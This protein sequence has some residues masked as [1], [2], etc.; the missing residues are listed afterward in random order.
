M[1]DEESADHENVKRENC[2][3]QTSKTKN[4]EGH[5]FSTAWGRVLPKFDSNYIPNLGEFIWR[6]C[7]GQLK[8]IDRPSESRFLLVPKLRLGMPGFTCRDASE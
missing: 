3:K 8:P 4:N 6:K 5:D 2:K 7:H 1:P